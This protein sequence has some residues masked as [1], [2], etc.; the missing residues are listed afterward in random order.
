MSTFLSIFGCFFHFLVL[1]SF[2][3]FTFPFFCVIFCIASYVVV[4]YVL[5][6]FY[7]LLEACLLSSFFVSLLLA[8]AGWRLFSFNLRALFFVD[9]FC[10]SQLGG[11][12]SVFGVPAFSGTSGPRG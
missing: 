1:L 5:P 9:F 12:F 4:V 7:F 11:N 10:L 2:F 8:P 6:L 3:Y